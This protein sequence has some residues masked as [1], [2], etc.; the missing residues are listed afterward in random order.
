MS[1]GTTAELMNYSESQT[2][3]RVRAVLAQNKTVYG[4][5]T[6]V[7]LYAGAPRARMVRCGLHCGAPPAVPCRG[8]PLAG[9]PLGRSVLRE[10]RG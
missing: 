4:G 8:T 7:P 9:S 5:G 2:V 10:R 3:L 6:G 1:W